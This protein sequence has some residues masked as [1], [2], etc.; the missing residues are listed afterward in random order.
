M[1][2]EAFGDNLLRLLEIPLVSTKVVRQG[3]FHHPRCRQQPRPRPRRANQLAKS[4]QHT[5][6]GRPMHEH[7]L[8]DT[9]QIKRAA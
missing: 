2:K 5:G 8:I 7:R 9:L 6:E 3:L 1:G 4:H